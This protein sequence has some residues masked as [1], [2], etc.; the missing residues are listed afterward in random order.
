MKRF[1]LFLLI[2][3]G[4]LFAVKNVV[5]IMADDMNDWISPYK[6]HSQ[7]ITPNIQK[8]ADKS[9]VFL[10]AY[11]PYPVCN[12][13]RTAMLTGLRP[14]TSGIV[15]NPQNFRAI[16][17][18][19]NTLTMP[20]YF[21][22]NGYY[23]IKSGKIFH[24]HGGA[25]DTVSWDE[26]SMDVGTTTPHYTVDTDTDMQFKEGAYHG[27]PTWGLRWGISLDKSIEDAG[28]FKASQYIIDKLS[29]NL[30][31]NNKP[32]FAAFGA[33]KP[34]LPWFSPE[35][36]Y[37]Y[38]DTAS[39]ILP[40]IFENDLDD[41]PFPNISNNVHEEFLRTGNWKNGVQ[42]YLTSISFA[43]SAVGIL[44]DYL[45]THPQK[46]STIIVFMGDHGWH[47]G[48]KNHWGKVSP[49]EEATKTP[50][51]VYDPTIGVS[52]Y[53]SH[54]VNLQDLY[55][56]LTDLVGLETPSH[57]EGR[58]FRAVLEDP[59]RED[60]VGWSL[61][62][63]RS[64]DAQ[65]FRT[66]KWYLIRYDVEPDVRYELY[67]MYTDMDQKDNLA[68]LPEHSDLIAKLSADIDRVIAGKDPQNLDVY[69]NLES[70]NI[71][72][73]RIGSSIFVH[74]NYYLNVYTP[75]GKRV[76]QFSGDGLSIARMLQRPNILGLPSARYMYTVKDLSK[77]VIERGLFY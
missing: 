21:K 75:H 43:D 76:K 18:L 55:A 44:L 16:D 63:A 17:S 50:L 15:S 60:W 54:V 67:N 27:D 12:P 38:Y 73:K 53:S 61:T 52:G 25:E 14:T 42:A 37:S 11:V 40:E 59:D 62:T 57:V 3:A 66:N 77:N 26:F 36:F 31:N 51:I 69:G 5:F 41:V 20:N 9:V 10:N 72:D 23:S 22:D 46:D 39:L 33:G 45:E 34:H 70:V 65:V 30:S 2:C 1:I 48:E 8:L 58:S 35:Y 19:K 68:E 49:W 47:L 32:F 56:T 28:D 71:L 6:G 74:K 24:K 7:A 4:H 29:N 13:S 64:G